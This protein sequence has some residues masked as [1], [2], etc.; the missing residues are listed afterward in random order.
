MPTT[1]ASAS[2]AEIAT[3]FVTVEEFARRRCINKFTA[4]HWLKSAPERLPR[5]TRLHGRVLF[6]ERDVRAFFEAFEVV[7]GATAHA[8]VSAPRPRRGRPRKAE[9]VAHRGAMTAGGAA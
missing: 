1:Q 8:E 4:Y 7:G 5:V 6:L 9:E 2:L 3:R